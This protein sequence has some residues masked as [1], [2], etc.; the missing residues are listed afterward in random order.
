MIFNWPIYGAV[1][2]VNYVFILCSLV[3][4]GLVTILALG[5]VVARALRN[6]YADAQD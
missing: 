4:G 5:V 1:A 3:V 2:L 6:H